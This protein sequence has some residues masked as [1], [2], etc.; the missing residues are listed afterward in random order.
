MIRI[1]RLP[2]AL[3]LIICF[4]SI[5]VRS[6]VPSRNT[7]IETDVLVFDST[8][9][10]IIAA[11]AAANQGQQVILLTEDSHVGGMRSSGLSMPNVGDINT[12]GGLGREFHD[13]VHQYYISEYGAE[14]EQVKDCESGFKFEPHVAEKVF[15]DWLLEAGVEILSE[16]MVVSVLKEGTRIV[17]VRTD[18]NRSIQAKVFIDASYEG[19]LLKQAGC[20]YRVGREAMDEYG[21]SLA[22]QRFPPEKAGQADQKTQRYVFRVCLTDITENQVPI[23]KPDNYHPATYMIDAAEMRSDP[24]ASL[25]RV[26]YLNM[27]P[28]RKTDVRVGEGWIGGSIDYPEATPAERKQIVTQHREYAQGYLWFLLTDPAVPEKVRNELSRWGYARDEF[29]DNDHWPYHLYIREARRLEGDFIMTQKDVLDDIY[30]DDAVAI[31]SFNLDVHPVQY[32]KISLDEKTWLYA[33]GGVVREG[34]IFTPLKPYEIPYRSLLP[35]ASEVQNLLVPVCLSSSHVAYSTIRMEPVYMM[36][37]HACG[38]AA[39]LSIEDKVKVHKISFKKLQ[40]LLIKQG[41]IIDAK[42]FQ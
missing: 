32:V 12:F 14:S 42:P 19:D 8:P 6:D 18:R 31:G 40:S 3:G 15:L 17:S 29:V 20:S 38:V 34:G 10:G 4:F 23:A 22:G 7:D 16:E 27:L 41:Q 5:S 30:K 36:L 13:R 9:A 26:I 21:E 24:P 37:G 11:I 25:N 35:R 33:T 2:V 39:S 28:N 1:L